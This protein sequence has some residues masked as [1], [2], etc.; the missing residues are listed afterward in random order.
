MSEISKETEIEQ[1]EAAQIA[2]QV[3]DEVNLREIADQ[4]PTQFY[5]GMSIRSAI[6]RVM[7][8]FATLFLFMNYYE[9]DQ[10]PFWLIIVVAAAF[11]IMRLNGRVNA[12]SRLFQL[13]TQQK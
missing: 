13:H 4:T 8:V 1:F 6:F 9:S 10:N 11:E 5:L 3:A 12:L 2:R 7:I